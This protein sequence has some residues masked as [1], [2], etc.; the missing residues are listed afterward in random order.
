VFGLKEL[1]YL[2][3]AVFILAKGKRIRLA[4]IPYAKWKTSCIELYKEAWQAFLGS[5][6]FTQR[7]AYPGEKKLQCRTH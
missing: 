6:V 5:P 3:C 7:I 1:P 2:L 4:L